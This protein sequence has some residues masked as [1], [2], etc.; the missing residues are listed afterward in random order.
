MAPKNKFT[1]NEI[2]LAAVQVV[3]KKGIGEL[4]ARAVATELGVSTQPIFTCF[5]T[6]DEA[7]KAVRDE[8]ENIY[9]KYITE[10]LNMSIP[11]YGFGMQYIRFAKDEPELYR[12]L[13]LT[14]GE[15]GKSGVMEEMQHSMNLAIESVKK[16]YDMNQCEAERYF[17]DMWLVAHSIATLIVTGNSP[18]SEGEIS[19]ILT[20]FSVGICTAIKETEGFVDNTFDRDEVFKKLTAKQ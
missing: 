9:N 8:A 2:T 7:K 3:R 14:A 10:G 1:R 11:F 13:F 16:T 17:R 6:M 18:Y 15:E 4:T 20:G 5:S 19:T 12:L